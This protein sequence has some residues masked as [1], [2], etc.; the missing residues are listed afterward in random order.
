[1]IAGTVSP[2]IASLATLENE[3][4]AA[5]TNSRYLS[6]PAGLFVAQTAEGNVMNLRNGDLYNP[7]SYL[8]SITT[9]NSNYGISPEAP[10]NGANFGNL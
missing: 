6:Q 9:G 2:M 1:M 10:Y 3:L 4:P 8:G 5:Y 7:Q